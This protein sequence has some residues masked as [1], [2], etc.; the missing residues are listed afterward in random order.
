MSG[1]TSRTF[2]PL[3]AL[4]FLGDL[5]TSILGV[6]SVLLAEFLSATPA[7]IG[8]VASGYGI[9]YLF[10]PTLLGRLGDSLGRRQSMLVA[11]GSWAA[12]QVLFLTLVRTWILAF[13]GTLLAGLAM[14]MFWPNASAHTSEIAGPRHDKVVATFCLSWA[15]GLAFG[16]FFTGIFTGLSYYAGYAAL[17]AISAIMGILVWKHPVFREVGNSSPS[18]PA[19]PLPKT[20][21]ESARGPFPLPASSPLSERGRAGEETSS[22]DVAL[23]NPRRRFR[24]YATFVATTL[25][26]FNSRVFSAF[27]PTYATNGA[28]GLGFSSF[29]MG[30]F[31]MSL[32]LGRAFTFWYCG[33]LR[34]AWREGVLMAAVGITAGLMVLFALATH[35]LGILCLMVGFGLCSGF[36]FTISFL[37]TMGFSTT[38]KGRNAGVLESLVGIGVIV[39][40]I[41]GGFLIDLTGLPTA[42]WLMGS[43]VTLVLFLGLIHVH[44]RTRKTLREAHS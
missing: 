22:L 13:V 41:L 11:I 9:T 33:R 29:L 38:G 3:Y 24:Y 42:P 18:S 8:I 21:K 1:T 27:F 37:F 6:A 10:A 5:S 34:P 31:L 30:A 17:L 14:G 23:K 12:I 39:A 2:L 20:G 25:Y 40:A 26:A 7:Q 16:P 44:A 28:S 43:A 35:W 19:P 4:G 36:L 32:G 15:L